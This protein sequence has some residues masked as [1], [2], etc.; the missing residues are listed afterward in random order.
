M[1]P[2]LPPFTRRRFLQSSLA[3]WAASS[4]LLTAGTPASSRPN[5]L[6]VVFDDLNDWIGC[7]GGYPGTVHTPNLDAL[8]RQG[9][10]FANA[11]CAIP[12]C[13]GSRTSTLTG[14]S[15]LQ[16]NV[17]YNT[18]HWRDMPGLA[19]TLT[20]PQRFRLAG[21]RSVGAGKVFHDND[22][23]SWDSFWP[24]NVHGFPDEPIQPDNEH[25]LKGGPPQNRIDTTFDWGVVNT[26]VEQTPDYQVANHVIQLLQTPSSQPLFIGCGLGKPHLPW[27]LPK[28]YFDR[29]PLD[30]VQL[31][32]VL[33]HDLD[34]VPAAARALVNDYLHK[35]VVRLGFWK[36]AVQAYLASITYADEQLGRVLQALKASPLADNTVVVVWS[37]HGWHLGEKMQWR[38]L[39]LWNEATHIPL[40]MAGPGIAAGQRVDAAVSLLD[41]V[42]TLGDL[43][44]LPLPQ[45]L[46]GRSL[47][48]LLHNSAAKGPW[49]ATTVWEVHNTVH[50][51]LRDGQ[52]RYTRY[53][54]G[55]EE[56]YDH[57]R[58]PQEWQN[59]AN[60]P[61][62]NTLKMQLFKTL[63][64]Q[65]EAMRRVVAPG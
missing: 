59:I 9:T 48:P 55:S 54:D 36:K 40:I 30:S 10:L 45:G 35:D 62:F 25:P 47:A 21:Y 43:C 64:Q 18:D 22:P 13:N 17:F 46:P 5:V 20:L 16:T 33:D 12:L 61:A 11:H 7:L 32:A 26:P 29:Y 42:P 57:Q 14:L 34:D 51:S 60:D 56:L 65:Q 8:A 38:K 6:M 53:A 44:H 28:A 23:A 41:I 63:Q 52:Y 39:T 58:D 15:P 1:T 49:S 2:L 50:A 37:D 19:N 3:W 4:G 27:F 24:N 31:P